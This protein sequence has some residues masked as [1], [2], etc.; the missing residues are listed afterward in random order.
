MGELSG[1][2]M[3]VFTIQV[4][5][6]CLNNFVRIGAFV[7][8]SRVIVLRKYIEQSP[9]TSFLGIFYAKHLKMDH[10]T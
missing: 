7:A 1:K 8:T 10:V 2:E 9:G 3:T 5:A 4:F 6:I